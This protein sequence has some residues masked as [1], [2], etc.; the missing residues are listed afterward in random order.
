MTTDYDTLIE[1]FHAHFGDV[2]IVPSRYYAP[3]RVNLIG[4]HTDYTGGLV[5]PCGIDRGTTLLVRRNDLGRFR[6]ASTNFSFVADLSAADSHHALDDHW[7]NYPLGV[8]N[9]FRARGIQVEGL[10]LM[11]SGDIPNGAGLSSSAS[12]E[13]V[14]AV[15]INALFTANLEAID[16][17]RLAQQAEREFVGMQCGIMDQFA[18]TMARED[19]AMMLDCH[20]LAY[21]QVPLQLNDHALVVINT[22]DRRELNDSAYNQRVAECERALGLLSQRM[23]ISRLGEL[24]PEALMAQADAFTDDPLALQRARHVATENARVRAAVPAL[25]T[26]DLATFGALMN[27]SHDSLATDYAVS[28][29]ALNAL[30]TAARNTDGVLGARLTGAGFGGCTV[31]LVQGHALD[32]FEAQVAEQYTRATGLTA[33]FYPVHAGQGAGLVE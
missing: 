24:T 27:D 31:N 15:A 13:V 12:I 14:T 20:S 18:V 28:S 32:Q 4:D 33:D 6:M 3:G 25:E 9:Q 7:V 1:R 19:H 16:I 26:G 5:F 30:V 11:Y 17:V 29:D 21:R 10:D 8:I 23:D 2:A 22:N